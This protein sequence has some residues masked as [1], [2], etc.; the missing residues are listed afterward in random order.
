MLTKN[1]SL[2]KSVWIVR[3]GRFMVE[4]FLGLLFIATAFGSTR[5]NTLYKRVEFC[6]VPMTEFGSI[7]DQPLLGS[8]SGGW[9]DRTR[10]GSSHS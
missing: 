1:W 6:L 8:V 10:V 4:Q 2:L 7:A 3:S 9:S 5:A